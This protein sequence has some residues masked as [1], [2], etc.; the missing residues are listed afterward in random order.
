[1]SKCCSGDF[2]LVGHSSVLAALVQSAL[3]T[4]NE[5]TLSIVPFSAL[6]E[7]QVGT[8]K[9]KGSWAITWANKKVDGIFMRLQQPCCCLCASGTSSINRCAATGRTRFPKYL[10]T[11]TSN[12]ICGHEMQGG[13]TGLCLKHHEH[14][15]LRLF[16][17]MLQNPCSVCQL[18]ICYCCRGKLCCCPEWAAWHGVCSS[19]PQECVSV[20]AHAMSSNIPPGAAELLLNLCSWLSISYQTEYRMCL[21]WMK[22]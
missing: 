21:G 20:T 8:K 18:N 1:M 10:W 15:S 13:L 16:T 14:W 6:P 4:R 2:L 17:W 19:A 12:L 7:K 11:R 3:C 5:C 22:W 9:G